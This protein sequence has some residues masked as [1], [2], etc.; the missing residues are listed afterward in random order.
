[1]KLFADVNSSYFMTYNVILFAI[2]YLALLVFS[3]A[4]YLMKLFSEFDGFVD[5]LKTN[6][7]SA[8]KNHLQLRILTY[9]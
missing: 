7:V 8:E 4:E 1:M 2:D 6:S 5:C 9:L 3:N